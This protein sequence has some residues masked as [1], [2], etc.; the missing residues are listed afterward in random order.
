MGVGRGGWAWV[1][2]WVGGRLA[3]LVVVPV[4]YSCFIGLRCSEVWK[5]GMDCG[6]DAG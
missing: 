4:H 5:P 1:A 2:G 3:L 6:D